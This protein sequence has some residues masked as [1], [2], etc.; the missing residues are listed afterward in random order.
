MSTHGLAFELG[1]MIAAFLAIG[2]A[3]WLWDWRR[4]RREREAA[5]RERAERRYGRTV[6]ELRD[7]Q[8][9]EGRK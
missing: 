5:K 2:G 8:E 6:M 1:A 9:R 3:V 7:K 4:E